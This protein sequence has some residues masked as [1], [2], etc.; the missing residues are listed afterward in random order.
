MATST[1]YASANS[2]YG[3][4]T[5][6]TNPTNVYADDGSYATGSPTLGDNYVGNIFSGFGFD[7]DIEV[8]ATITSVTITAQF[9]M[10]GSGADTY[11]LNLQPYIDGSAYGSAGTNSAGPTV[12]TVVS[13]APAGMD[14][15]H[16]DDASFAVALEGIAAANGGKTFNVDYVKAVIVYTNPAPAGNSEFLVF[17]I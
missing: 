11:T 5:A 7:A 14:Q 3:G 12:D 15:T 1:K 2:A 6:W 16:V 8:G 4:E 17:F 9:K 13:I 10:T